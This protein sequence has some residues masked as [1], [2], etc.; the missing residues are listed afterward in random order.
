LKVGG[1]AELAIPSH[2]LLKNYSCSYRTY[3]TIFRLL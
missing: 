1:A 3:H 2:I